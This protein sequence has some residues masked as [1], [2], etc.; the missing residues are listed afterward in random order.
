[1]DSK[2]YSIY[3]ELR[4]NNSSNYKQK[5]LEKYKDN[6]ILKT[7]LEYTFTPFKQYYL[8]QIPD[9]LN[10]DGPNDIDYALKFLDDLSNR[11]YTGNDARNR[12]T[13][14]LESI[15]INDAKV[16]LHILDRSIDAG[17]SAKTI[18]KV[19]P[20][21]IPEIPY[22]RCDK[23]SDKTKKNIKYPALVQ[24]KA[25]GTFVNIVKHNKQVYC[26]TRNGSQFWINKVTEYFEHILTDV[27]NIVITGEAVI[28]V[29]GKPLV[30]KI[31]NGR[32]NSYIKREE[33]RERI[34]DNQKDIIKKGKGATKA[35]DNLV[36]ELKEKEIDWSFTEHNL[37]IEG[38]DMIDFNDWI[39]GE[40]NINYITRFERFKDLIKD[41]PF[42][43]AIDTK[44]VETFDEAMDYANEMMTIGLEG[45]VLKNKM[46]PWEN[47]TS[48]NQIKLKAELDADLI[49][50]GYELGEGE[51]T[52]GIGSIICETADGEL[53]VSVGSGLSREQRGLQRVDE[54]DM[55]K[56]L[57]L[58]EDL[59][60][61]DDFFKEQ[62][63]GKIIT[64]LY[65]EVISSGGKDRLSLFLPRFVEIRFDK[66][67]AD[68]VK[69]LKGE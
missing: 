17:I 31:G 66:D 54:N 60:N 43:T 52:G 39:K 6:E 5:C 41:C 24:L 28:V 9:F 23:L 64:V 51:F 2:I 37:V 15:S 53:S 44:E 58:R 68:T 33:V 35:F 69:R 62:Y 4:S 61:I 14:V 7:V 27:D 57:I 21:L 48:K 19:W 29:D 45:G 40:S 42:I 20:N 49:C 32:I 65:N 36:N 11:V 18:N 3:E 30:R 38:W 10:V 26:M 46:A 59:T 56:G 47:K 50:V 34:I 1:M 13:E 55:T 12:L 8:K 67:T 25:D 16:I 22:M 63:L